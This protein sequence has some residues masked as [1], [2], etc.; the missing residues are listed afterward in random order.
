M[1]FSWKLCF[2]TILISLVTF[3]IGGYVLISAL[4][5]STYEREIENAVEENQMFQY[6]FVAYWNTTVQDSKIT[7]ENIEKTAN[8]MIQNSITV[9]N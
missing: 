5:Q 4:F 2:A 8:V 7:K 3:S 6:S 9:I 1:K